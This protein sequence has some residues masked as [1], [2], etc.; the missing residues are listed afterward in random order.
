MEG[1]VASSRP[2]FLIL[3]ILLGW[4]VTAFGKSGFFS[5]DSVRGFLNQELSTLALG[6]DTSGLSDHEAVDLF[7]QEIDKFGKKSVF[8]TD[9]DE[10][11]LTAKNFFGSSDWFKNAMPGLRK[12]IRVEN[13]GLSDDEVEKKVDDQFWKYVS[14]HQEMR[15]VDPLYSF[16]LKRLHERGHLV[17]GLTAR[18]PAMADVT[19]RQL[20]SIGMDF[21]YTRTIFAPH[22]EDWTSNKGDILLKTSQSG[23]EQWSQGNDF[24]RLYFF[25]DSMKE[26]NAVVKSFSQ[27]QAP[28][29]KI[30]V[31][32]VHSRVSAT[33]RDS[34][35]L[36]KSY[37][38]IGE[39]QQDVYRRTNIRLSNREAYRYSR[40]MT[41]SMFAC[42]SF[43]K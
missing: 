41:S 34:D 3:T 27:V 38:A 7:I 13:P 5:I 18:K 14:E 28:Q 12:S 25:D 4:T 43:Y 23:F 20:R 11:L 35:V 21:L 24:F 39:F 32:V 16:F 40:K 37:E 8:V 6:K 31:K 15:S 1:L 10:T 33:N 9:L 19:R 26:I 2:V 29:N 36:A 17:L 22:N 42:R 30:E